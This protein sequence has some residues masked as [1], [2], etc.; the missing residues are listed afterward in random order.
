MPIPFAKQEA[1]AQGFRAL[2]KTVESL[3][4]FE[5]RIQRAFIFPIDV[6][7]FHPQ[8]GR[9][10]FDAAEILDAP[11]IFRRLVH[12]LI[13]GNVDDFESIVLVSPIQFF[14]RL[15]LRRKSAARHRIDD[16]QGFAG[17]IP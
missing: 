14:Q 7:F 11:V 13:T 15:V 2:A 4:G 12:E 17:E 16:E 6:G 5:V 1:H 10:I 9:I 3:L 8:K